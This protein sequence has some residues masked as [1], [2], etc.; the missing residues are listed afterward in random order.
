MGLNVEFSNFTKPYALLESRTSYDANNSGIYFLPYPQE[1]THKSFESLF[2][3]DMFYLIFSFKF[4]LLK[5]GLS[6][7]NCQKMQTIREKIF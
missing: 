4:T 7:V 5:D 2:L 6:F 3:S 1:K